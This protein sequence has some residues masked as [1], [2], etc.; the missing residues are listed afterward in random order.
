MGAGGDGQSL[1]VI[2]LLPK[3]AAR[4]DADAPAA[5]DHDDDAFVFEDEENAPLFRQNDAAAAVGR[6]AC[7]A[8][9]T[10]RNEG[11]GGG[12]EGEGGSWWW[13]AW[14]RTSS[15]QVR[16][17]TLYTAGVTSSSLTA[18]SAR[19]MHDDGLAVHWIVLGRASF[20]MFLTAYL[21]WYKGVDNPWGHRRGMLCLRAL[22]GKGRGKGGTG[23]H[24]FPGKTYFVCVTPSEF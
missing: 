23:R 4:S 3:L 11:G 8:D 14:F 9:G 15:D 24:P 22:L 7:A 17:L 13:P 18:L 1:G 20:G 10:G 16:G 21:L 6:K 12:G 2:E 5:A 19:L